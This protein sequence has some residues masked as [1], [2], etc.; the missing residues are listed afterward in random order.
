MVES[1]YMANQVPYGVSC[2]HVD[3]DAHHHEFK[4]H[5]EGELARYWS[6]MQGLVNGAYADVQFGGEFND[7]HNKIRGLFAAAEQEE[8]S[9]SIGHSKTVEQN[10]ILVNK[11][12][13]L[14]SYN[15]SLYSV[16]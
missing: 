8:R 11:A 7:S 2:D 12:Q 4:N 6:Q 10:A 13:E 1:F 9:L 3:V 15:A 5:I 16:I 14:Q